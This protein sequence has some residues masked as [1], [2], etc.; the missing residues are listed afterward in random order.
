M[1]AMLFAPSLLAQA[2]SP[3]HLGMDAYLSL[4]LIIIAVGGIAFIIRIEMRQRELAKEQER[5]EKRMEKIEAEQDVHAARTTTLEQA[6]A[7]TASTLG[8]IDGGVTRIEEV[9]LRMAMP[10]GSG[11]APRAKSG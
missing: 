4:P 7:V 9:L 3:A 2:S 8:R 5:Q 6:Q 11:Q 1:R 10:A